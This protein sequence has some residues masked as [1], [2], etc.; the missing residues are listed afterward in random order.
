MRRPIAVATLICL[1]FAAWAWLD[2]HAAVAPD[3]SDDNAFYVE[4]E[5]VDDD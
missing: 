4:Y 3:A 2:G 1:A 5:Q